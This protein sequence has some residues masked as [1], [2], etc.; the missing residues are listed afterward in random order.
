MSQEAEQHSSA[1][2]QIAF[3]LKAIQEPKERAALLTDPHRH[4]TRNNIA[5]DPGFVEAL[6]NEV[7]K[8]N[9]RLLDVEK[10]HGISV[11]S[12]AD[13]SMQP[14]TVRPGEVA[15]LPAVVAVAAVVSA[16]AAVVTAVTSVYQA[17]KWTEM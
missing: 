14:F 5:L 12:I 8:I 15:V 10:T 17:T 13:V 3:V 1:L 11:S 16:A 7:N 9:D 2:D 6:R 4:A